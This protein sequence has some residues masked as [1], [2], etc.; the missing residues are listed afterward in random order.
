M[1]DT[2]PAEYDPEQYAERTRNPSGGGEKHK[3]ETL[4]KHSAL[5]P[6]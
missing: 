4:V 1:L 3:V 5:K 6:L 2:P